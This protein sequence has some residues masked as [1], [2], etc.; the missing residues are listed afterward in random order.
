[1]SERTFIITVEVKVAEGAFK[2]PAK[3]FPTPSLLGALAC[4]GAKTAFE[5][6]TLLGEGAFVGRVVE[7]RTDGLVMKVS[8]S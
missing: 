7:V 4:A 8:E 1:M 2:G 3:H 6:A 5:P